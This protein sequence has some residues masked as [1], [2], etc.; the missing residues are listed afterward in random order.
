MGIQKYLVCG[1]VRRVYGTRSTGMIWEETCRQA[2]LDSLF[3]AGVASP[4]CFKHP[5]RKVALV[6]HG[7]NFTALGKAENLNWYEAQLAKSLSLKSVAGWA[8]IQIATS[9]GFVT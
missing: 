9:C 3:I 7:H 5:G 2:L 4:C 1:Q 6:V 8:N